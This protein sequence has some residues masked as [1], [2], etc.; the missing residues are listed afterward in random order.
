[1]AGVSGAIAIGTITIGEIITGAATCGTVLAADIITDK[2]CAF[3]EAYRVKKCLVGAVLA[4]LVLIYPLHATEPSACVSL[5]GREALHQSGPVFLTSFPGAGPGPLADVAFLYDNA[6]A[7]IALVGCGYTKE[8]AQIGDAMLAALDHDRYWA[9][10]RLRNGYLAG[11]V[12]TFPVKL[13]GWWDTAQNKW[14]EDRYQVGSD[15]GN[16]AWAML[17]LLTVY[18]ATKAPQYRDGAERIGKY[19]E[20]SLSDIK[21]VGFDGGTFGHEPSPDHNS[22]KATEHNTDLAAA[23]ARLAEDTKDHHWSI[24]AREARR[25]VAAMWRPICPCFAAGTATDGHSQNML[26]ALDAQL[27]PVLALPDAERRY[28]GVFVTV[29]QRLRQD[30][31]YAYSEVREGMWTEGTAQAAL[32][33]S[34]LG[35]QNRASDLLTALERQRSPDGSY[36]ASS[37]ASLPTGFMLQTDPSKPRLYFHVPHLAALAWVALAEE[38]FNP[39]TG[40]VAL[41]K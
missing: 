1:M 41:L 8:A 27:W 37:T 12:K 39:F 3:S 5:A 24:C 38:R 4:L 33:F 30:D 25:F 20:K 34:L 13:A 29:E 40:R 26:L 35:Q 23:F 6:V 15:T 28:S 32:L 21:P 22:W 7:V 11:A 10:G 19:V 17:A 16:M 9:D 18:E 31:G 2:L 36:Y 14:V